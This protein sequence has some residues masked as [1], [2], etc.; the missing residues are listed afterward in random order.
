MSTMPCEETE[1]EKTVSKEGKR[2]GRTYGRDSLANGGLGDVGLTGGLHVLGEEA[3]LDVLDRLESLVLLVEG[4]DKVLD[5]GHGEL[6]VRK[7][8]VSGVGPNSDRGNEDEPNTEET[9]ARGDFVTE[10]TTDLSR[11]EGNTAVVKLEEAVEVDEVTLG[12][13][14]AEV[15]TS[16][17][18]SESRSYGWK[19]ED[20]RRTP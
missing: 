9:S 4:V 5:L 3:K 13:L 10:R 6:T 14:G 17:G 20:C 18:K 7:E 12:S 19:G 15:T 1:G 16:R 8:G 2:G 11:G